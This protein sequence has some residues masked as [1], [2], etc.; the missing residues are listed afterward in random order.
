MKLILDLTIRLYALLANLGKKSIKIDYKI[1][2]QLDF[3][4]LYH[5]FYEPPNI[6]LTVSKLT[7]VFTRLTL[8]WAKIFSK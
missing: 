7:T 6:L 2:I 1:N 5:Y 3:A 8:Y 4:L